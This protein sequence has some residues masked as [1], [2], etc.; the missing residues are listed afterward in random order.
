[1]TEPAFPTLDFLV[2]RRKP[3]EIAAS[4]FGPVLGL[5]TAWRLGLP[6]LALFG[7]AAGAATLLLVRS[8]LE[9]VTLISDMLLPK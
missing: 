8:Y 9:L 6:E 4:A 3:L 7:I 2:R 1:M 5:Y